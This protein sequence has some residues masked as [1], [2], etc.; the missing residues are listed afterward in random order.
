MIFYHERGMGMSV[1]KA[2]E[3][4][5]EMKIVCNYYRETEQLLDEN[6]IGII[7]EY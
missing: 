2:W 3:W 6:K 5:N 7:I 4:D 1:S